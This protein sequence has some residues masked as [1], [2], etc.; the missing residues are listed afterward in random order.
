MMS[1]LRWRWP[2]PGSRH[3]P[4]YFFCSPFSSWLTRSSVRN[5]WEQTVV[6]LSFSKSNRHLGMTWENRE[7]FKKTEL[8]TVMES[9]QYFAEHTL[10][11]L[12]I[13][14]GNEYVNIAT[15]GLSP[16]VGATSHCHQVRV[17]GL[18]SILHLQIMDSQEWCSLFFVLP[19]NRE[20]SKQ[21]GFY[22]LPSKF[23]EVGSLLHNTLFW[24]AWGR[25]D[26][27][28]IYLM[29]T[30]YLAAAEEREKRSNTIRKVL[31]LCPALWCEQVTG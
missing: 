9:L 18:D 27:F 17:D 22:T 14:M 1:S 16:T 11:G 23:W 4:R 26:A 7:N 15:C 31:A 2:G 5:P 13:R 3:T 20:A 28:Y 25:T 29:C 6:W 8:T 19:N 24:Q 10:V 30:H 12:A 21:A